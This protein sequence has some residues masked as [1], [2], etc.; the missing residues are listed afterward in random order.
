[1][2]L[3]DYLQGSSQADLAK[4]LGVHPVLVHQWSKGKRRIPAERCPA[5]EKAT[6]GAV[7]CEELMPDIDWAYLRRSRSKKVA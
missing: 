3:L 7:R 4:A 5:I 6:A 2:K 1:M